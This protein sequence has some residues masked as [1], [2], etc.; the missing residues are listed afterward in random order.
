M[1]ETKRGLNSRV[2]LVRRQTNGVAHS[3]AKEV[4]LL[5]SPVTYYDIFNCIETLIINE[6]L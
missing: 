2:E 5:A 6:M 4:T 1:Y 3:L